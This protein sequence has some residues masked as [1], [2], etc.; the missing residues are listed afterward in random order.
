MSTPTPGGATM[1]TPIGA[2]DRG[3]L[4]W[5]TRHR[6]HDR[7]VRLIDPRF[8]DERFHDGL[9]RLREQRHAHALDIVA[10]G[11]SGGA[12][13]VEYAVDPPS[14]SLGE[15]L[16]ERPRWIDRLRLLYQLCDALARWESQPRSPLS[17]GLYN[18]VFTGVDGDPRPWILPCPAVNLL[19]PNDLFG[20]DPALLAAVAPETV[21]GVSLQD[22]TQDRYALGT[23]VAQAVGCRPYRLAR[24]DAERVEAQGRGALL[25]SVERGCDVEPVVR[26]TPAIAQLF[27]VVQRYRHAIPEARPASF[28]QLRSALAAA[29][30]LVG[31]AEAL[32][33]ADPRAAVDVLSW[34]GS[35]DQGRHAACL[36]LAAEICVE[37]GDPVAALQHLDRAIGHT[38]HHLDLRRSRAL[39]LA[40]LQ[41]AAP[42][43]GGEPFRVDD[44]IEDLQFVDRRQLER[45]PAWVWRLARAYRRAHRPFDEAAA[46]HKVIE[47]DA[48][49]LDALHRYGECLKELGDPGSA[50]A[51]VVRR[52]KPR[53]DNL[54]AA[55]GW[56]EETRTQWHAKFDSLID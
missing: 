14:R 6:E 10:E 36:L 23:L 48:R 1:T 16:A 11:W 55:F 30:D 13:A 18:V 29:T 53:V 44:L 39:L 12:Y 33:P 9:R 7:I 25:A 51:A 52:A 43:G 8:C 47:L 26:G 2:T 45:D 21:R 46:V 41:A 28:G 34:V 31:L 38:P 54:A 37:S 4:W 42:Q 35:G 15:L 24:D 49:D 56:S 5:A 17:V 3:T 27:S 20:L 40:G 50:V 32:R 22:R 19:A